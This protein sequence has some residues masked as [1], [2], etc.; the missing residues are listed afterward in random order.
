MQ[1][2]ELY[3]DNLFV[4]LLQIDTYILLVYLERRRQ[5][6]SIVISRFKVIRD[7][8]PNRKYSS[9]IAGVPSIFVI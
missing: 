4:L 8:P 9:T 3:T 7:K 6:F 5:L 2:K 1:I